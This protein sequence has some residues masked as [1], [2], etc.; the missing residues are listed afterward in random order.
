MYCG[1]PALALCFGVLL[2]AAFGVE[3]KDTRFGFRCTIPDGFLEMDQDSNLK[4]CLYRYFNGEPSP[5]DI[6]Q[7]VKIQRLH[8]TLD[9]QQRLEKDKLPSRPGVKF[10]LEETPWSGLTLDIVRSEATLSA[11][12]K[13]VGYV[14]QFPLADEAIQLEVSGPWEKDAEVRQVLR[15]VVGSFQPLKPLPASS[16]PKQ[17]DPPPPAEPPATTTASEKPIAAMSEHSPA[18]QTA[19][20]RSPLLRVVLPTLAFVLIAAITIGAIRAIRN[21]QAGS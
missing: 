15:S 18:E 7:L 1:I 10:T 3:I 16:K 20:P 5:G 19:K 11:K 13:Y 14:V 12:D 4:E 17:P 8:G 6:P 21:H 9:P 2:Q